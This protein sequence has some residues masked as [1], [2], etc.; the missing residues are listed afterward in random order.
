MALFARWSLHQLAVN[1]IFFL[2]GDLDE[3]VYMQQPS[4]FSSDSTF[5][6]KIDKTIYDLK[7]TPFLKLYNT[8][9][10]MDF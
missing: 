4:S 8:L 5:V 6:C 7:Q 1:N 2:N 3:D 9:I 10:Y